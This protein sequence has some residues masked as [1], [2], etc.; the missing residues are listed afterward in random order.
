M[1]A[2]ENSGRNPLPRTG[3]R[4]VPGRRGPARVDDPDV[5][6]AY[7]PAVLAGLRSLPAPSAETVGAAGSG[8]GAAV[9]TPWAVTAGAAAGAAAALA[10]AYG[11]GRRTGRPAARRA[12]GPVALFFERR[13]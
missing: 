8:P 6:E 4:A 10:L 2:S 7:E 13:G 9:R 12:P 5:D 11:W 1:S 3:V